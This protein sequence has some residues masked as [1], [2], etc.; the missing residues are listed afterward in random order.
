MNAVLYIATRTKQ[1]PVSQDISLTLAECL[2][3]EI[4]HRIEN[5]IPKSVFKVSVRDDDHVQTIRKPNSNHRFFADFENFKMLDEFAQNIWTDFVYKNDDSHVVYAQN[6]S[7]AE[8]YGKTYTPLNFNEFC[9]FINDLEISIETLKETGE[10]DCSYIAD[11]VEGV[12]HLVWLESY[13]AGL[14]D[15]RDTAQACD[16]LIIY[17]SY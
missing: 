9:G 4:E 1:N 10:W 11:N 13:V 6:C 16:G 3:F 15:V 7:S 14:K 12:E 2:N 17:Y 5:G 8:W